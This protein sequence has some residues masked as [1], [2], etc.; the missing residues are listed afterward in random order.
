MCR[1]HSLWKRSGQLPG[2]QDVDGKK[3]ANLWRT[4][5]TRRGFEQRWTPDGSGQYAATAQGRA[6]Q[7]L[8]AGRL[9]AT[10]TQGASGIRSRRRPERRCGCSQPFL[11]RL[12]SSVTWL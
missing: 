12:V 1:S 8:S 10:T 9:D 2:P 11:M 3:S 7:R 5:V 4:A 6:V